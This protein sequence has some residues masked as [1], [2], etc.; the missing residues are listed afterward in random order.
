MERGR[1]AGSIHSSVASRLAL[2]ILI[3]SPG[4]STDAGPS[5]G[6]FRMP[7]AKLNRYHV[8]LFAVMGLLGGI[9]AA[10]LPLEKA[11]L[12]M[13]I[14]GVIAGVGLKMINRKQKERGQRPPV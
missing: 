6:E 7:K 14:V 9:V 3:G 13:I 11:V 10:R 8:L 5:N 1:S 2:Q 4:A 12:T